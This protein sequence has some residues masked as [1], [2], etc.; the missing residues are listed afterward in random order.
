MS[1]ND[2]YEY[3]EALTTADLRAEIAFEESEQASALLSPDTCV[4]H[5]DRL[6]RM[7]AVL[8]GRVGTR[9]IKLTGDQV[10]WLCGIGPFPF[11]CNRNTIDWPEHTEEEVMA[12]MAPLLSRNS[13]AGLITRKLMGEIE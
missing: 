8:A 11:T 13:K 7:R 12:W 4:Y 9:K 3:I 10:Q 6:R 5:P 2:T 1:R